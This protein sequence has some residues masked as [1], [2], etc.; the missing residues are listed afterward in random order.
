MVTRL[1]GTVP[2][3]PASAYAVRKTLEGGQLAITR[4]SDAGVSTMLSSC[5]S[6]ILS[7]S[8]PGLRL[9]VFTHSSISLSQ[10]R[11]PDTHHNKEPFGCLDALTGD[12]NIIPCNSTCVTEAAVDHALAIFKMQG[13]PN[14]GIDLMI[15]GGATRLPEGQAVFGERAKTNVIDTLM[16]LRDNFLPFPNAGSLM[17]FGYRTIDLDSCSGSVQMS[18]SVDNGELEI[19]PQDTYD[20]LIKR[21]M[22]GPIQ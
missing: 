4:N 20:S 12:V 13:I 8:Q 16:Y 6:V 3:R 14:D 2:I 10:M 19:T 18:L 17:G 22:A 1:Y 21:I 9:N 7:A 5:V 15:F 11:H